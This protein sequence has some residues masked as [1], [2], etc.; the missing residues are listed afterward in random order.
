MCIYVYNNIIYACRNGVVTDEK[1]AVVY[2]THTRPARIYACFIFYRATFGFSSYNN[3]AAAVQRAA[4]TTD[5]V[6]RQVGG[7][8][9]GAGKWCA[10]AAREKPEKS[11]E[12]L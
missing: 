6:H 1:T 3:I 10:L 8:A 5:G 9:F 11:C 4:R 2:V 7:R 12:N